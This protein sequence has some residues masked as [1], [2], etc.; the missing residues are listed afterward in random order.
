MKFVSIP[1]QVEAVQYTGLN[2]AELRTFT[3]DSIIIECGLLPN[4]IDVSILTKEGEMTVNIGDYVV[5]EPFPT[6][7]RD[8]YPCKGEIFEKRYKRLADEA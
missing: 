3:N 7:D 8:Y 2:F 6:G 4:Q 1:V 5:R